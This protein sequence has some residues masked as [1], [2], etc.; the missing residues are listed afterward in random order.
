[1]NPFKQ[2]PNELCQRTASKKDRILNVYIENTKQFNIQLFK[3]MLNVKT[4][5]TTTSVNLTVDS[6]VWWVN[7]QNDSSLPIETHA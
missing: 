2:T 3:T 4:T 7:V 6:L 5:V 1:M